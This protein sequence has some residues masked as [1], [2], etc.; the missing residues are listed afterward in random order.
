MYILQSIFIDPVKSEE[1]GIV[2]ECAILRLSLGYRD[3]KHTHSG[4][5]TITLVTRICIIQFGSI[6]VLVCFRRIHSFRIKVLFF[7]TFVVLLGYL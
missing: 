7:G 1:I 3:I 2:V 5:Q 6:V 4:K